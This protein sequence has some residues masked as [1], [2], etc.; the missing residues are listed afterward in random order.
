MIQVILVGFQIWVGIHPLPAAKIVVGCGGHCFTVKTES[1]CGNFT[2]STRRLLVAAPLAA[3][4]FAIG[5]VLLAALRWR[6]SQ[7]I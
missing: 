6:H 2:N 1:L 5:T 3:S 7:A 4:G